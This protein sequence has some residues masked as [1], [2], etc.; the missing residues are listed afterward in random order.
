[1][2]LN[3]SELSS[4]NHNHVRSFFLHQKPYGK[5][6]NWKVHSNEL[7]GLIFR[8]F[9]HL[10]LDFINMSTLITWK[11]KINRIV[12][13]CD[14]IEHKTYLFEIHLHAFYNDLKKHSLKYLI[15]YNQTILLTQIKKWSLVIKQPST[16]TQNILRKEHAI[17]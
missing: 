2:N 6:L 16:A 15:I 11:Y 13:P 1:M 14:N 5:Y 10:I 12:I 3:E 4:F 8:C 9:T 7:G 17:N